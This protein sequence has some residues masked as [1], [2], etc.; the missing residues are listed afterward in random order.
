M[1]LIRWFVRQ[2]VRRRLRQVARALGDPAATQERLL[3]DLVRRAART[4]WGR[5]HGY[6]RIRSVRDFQQA[7][8]V[9]RYE[10]LAP[11]WHRAFDG[12]RDV[13]WPGHIRYFAQSSG[14]TTGT[15]KLLPVSDDMVRQNLRSGAELVGVVEQQTPGGDLVGGQTLYFGGC[16]KLKE[17]GACW[18]GDASGIMARRVPPFASRFRLPEPEVA[19]LDDWERKVETICRRYL[20]SPVRAVAGLPMWSL[21]LLNRLVEAAA[22]RRGRPVATVAEAWPQMRAYIYF[23]MSIEPYREQFDELL[24]PS[25]ATVATYSSSEGGMNA[26]QTEQADPS[27]RL[28]LDCGAFY[29]FVPVRELDGPEPTRLTLDQVELDQPYAI[30]LSAVSGVWAYDV[31]DIVRFTS[32]RPPKIAFAG[33]THLALNAFGEH[34]IQ[35]HLDGAMGAACRATGAAVRDFTVT[36]Y[37]PSVVPPCG[38]HIWLIEFAGDPP[39]IE[40]FL[41]HL[42]AH[43]KAANDD[44]AKYRTNDYAIAPPRAE[45]L[46]PG[47]FYEWARR[48]GKLGGQHKVPRVA[49][50]DEMVDELRELSKALAARGPSRPSE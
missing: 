38:G 20:D 48:H 23:G 25:I 16:T 27:M 42:D 34:L 49:R 41:G 3:L 21:I 40:P 13:T 31:G 10:D 1:G 4:E 8:P 17:V 2:A 36:P 28:V 47:T 22:E 50:S 24:G 11:L 9:S 19:A 29:E 32:L 35:E 37:F 18:Q 14:T 39:A 15:T 44:Y 45:V 7:V 12:G 5:A 43:I 46:A 6:G 26:I 30:L 33:R